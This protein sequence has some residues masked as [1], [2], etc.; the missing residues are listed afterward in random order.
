MSG[1]LAL[2]LL[3]LQVLYIMIVNVAAT[4]TNAS[5][6]DHKLYG[7]SPQAPAAN[8]KPP[9]N[10]RKMPSSP[11]PPMNGI[12]DGNGTPRN[13]QSKGKPVP[14][15]FGSKVTGGGNA[16]PQTPKDAAELKAWLTDKVPRVILIRRTYDFSLGAGNITAAACRPWKA[17]TNGLQVQT[18]KDYNNWCSKDQKLPSNI[19]V[20]T[21]LKSQ[22]TTRTPYMIDDR[23]S[24]QVSLQASPMDPIK[25]ASHKTLLGVGAAGIIKGKGPE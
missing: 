23:Y 1:S 22:V 10:N 7:R 21:D 19:Q 8:S 18:A 15:G 6:L 14:F 11:G 5:T 3:G 16:A 24:A 17:C 9:G 25:V 4:S 13:Q 20:G 2:L 12:D